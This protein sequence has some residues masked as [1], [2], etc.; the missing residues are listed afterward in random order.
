[1]RVIAGT[2]K[3]R[4]LHSVKGQAVRPTADRVKEALFSMLGSRFDL[5]G[6][7][8]LDLF[9]GS[10]ALGIE[11]LSRGAEHVTFV[12]QHSGTCRVLRQNVAHCG[13]D[14]CSTVVCDSV[15]RCLRA[16]AREPAKFNG[17]FV[18]PPYGRELAAHSVAELASRSLLE[19]GAWVVVE[20]HVDDA[21][22]SAYGLLHLTHTRRYGK[23]CLSLFQ[24]NA[25]DAAG[26]QR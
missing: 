10:G 14:A 3:G 2:A 8:L 13:F 17:A 22:A 24:M 19:D 15:E 16:L 26:S 20:H 23:T 25:P 9:A 4:R 5:E 21:L 12:E 18:D 6:A 1:M 11:A 7:A